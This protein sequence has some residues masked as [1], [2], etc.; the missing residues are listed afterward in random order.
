MSAEQPGRAEFM[1]NTVK[2]R[3]WSINTLPG[4]EGPDTGLGQR[5]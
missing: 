1:Y 2:L 5:G 3:K 4:V